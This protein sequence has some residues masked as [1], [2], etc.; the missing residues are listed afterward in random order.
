[1]RNFE[2]G[3]FQ[4][5]DIDTYHQMPGLSSSGVKLILDCPM[6]YFWQYHMTDTQSRIDKMNDPHSAA[7][8]I[9]TALHTLVLE[10]YK[11]DS[12]FYTLEKKQKKAEIKHKHPAKVILNESEWKMVVGMHEGISEN[13][14][15]DRIKN[16]K[17]E[18][19]LFWEGGLFKTKLRSRPDVYDD[20]III[21]IK[22]T[23]SIQYFEREIFS[24]GYHRQAAMQQDAIHYF[25][26]KRL[27]VVLFVVEKKEPYL[28][29]CFELDDISIEKGREEYLDAALTYTECLKHN[30]WPGYDKKFKKVELPR[31]MSLGDEEDDE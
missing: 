12:I 14:L 19:S 24:N 28:T 18:H 31:Y 15:F 13:P 20:E 29:A 30:N 21:D 25:E 7:L 27:P 10:E 3:V 26:A 2:I 5:I 23:K 22:T 6:R 16:G 11:F 1:M 8:R 17:I 9:G 4:D